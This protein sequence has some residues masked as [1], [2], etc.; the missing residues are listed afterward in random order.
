MSYKNLEIWQLAKQLVMDI[1]KMALS[2][3]PKCE[4]LTRYQ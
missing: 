1:H 3:I 4:L 2:D